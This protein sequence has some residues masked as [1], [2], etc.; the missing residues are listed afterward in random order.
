MGIGL[1]DAAGEWLEQRLS[2]ELLN[3]VMALAGSQLARWL[4]LLDRRVTGA[5]ESRLRQLGYHRFQGT[6]VLAKL[7]WS[8]VCGHPTFSLATAPVQIGFVRWINFYTIV[9][10]L[11]AAMVVSIWFT[12][13]KASVCCDNLTAVV[14][15][16]AAQLTSAGC[17]P[18]ISGSA[19]GATWAPAAAGTKPFTGT[20]S[21]LAAWLPTAPA[22]GGGTVQSG[23][24]VCTAFPADG[25]PLDS[26]L[27]GL[28][29][30]AVSL[31]VAVI[32]SNLLALSTSTDEEQ[33]HS[34]TRF[35]VWPVV[36]IA[37]L[38]KLRWRFR[39]APRDAVQTLKVQM[40]SRWSH[41]ILTKLTVAAADAFAAAA[42]AC[43]RTGRDRAPVA[44]LPLALDEAVPRE[45][46]AGNAHAALVVTPSGGHLGWMGSEGGIRGAP[47]PYAGAVEWLVA[48]AAESPA[49]AAAAKMG[50]EAR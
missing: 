11:V 16:S 20:C 12:Y 13:S 23:T 37:A 1:A 4:L 41:G 33:L 45:A 27:S 42:R 18:S 30:F 31:P 15:C 46:I 35:M 6:R 10:T 40:A 22:A 29:S 39:R 3:K 24:F 14:G 9:T 44:P 50:A 38:G 19:Y 8:V 21:G 5:R 43:R 32:V 7:R 26:F 47:W 17:L 28:I 48:A 49:E 34:R 2:A 36:Y 25:N